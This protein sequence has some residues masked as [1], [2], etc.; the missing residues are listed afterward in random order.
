MKYNYQILIE[1]EGTKYFGWQIQKKRPTI[2]GVL[3]NAL[4]KY[5]KKRIIIFGAGR[6][7]TGVHACAQ[8][9]HF[10]LDTVIEK[11]FKFIN[12][13]NFF[14]KKKDVSILDIKKKKLNFHSRFN[15][16]KR[17]YKYYIINRIG[18]LKLRRKRAWHIKNY[19][20]L[21]KMK[22]GAVLLK[23]TK[24]FSTFRSSSCGAKS[25][26]KTLNRVNITKKGNLIEITFVSKSFLQQQ[27]RSMVGCLKYLAESKWTLSKFKEVM[28]SK[29]RSNCAPPA[30]SEGLFLVKVFY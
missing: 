6:T 22:K 26:I 16:K 4:R 5:F 1:Y 24:D 13:I 7:D 28:I 8:S 11:K 19:L 12:T 14:L 9:A 10:F 20:D 29:K 2:Q 15:A 30:P 18:D 27:V 3:Q 25:P 23:G 17:I 21:N